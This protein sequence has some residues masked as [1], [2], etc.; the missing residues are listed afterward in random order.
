MGSNLPGAPKHIAKGTLLFGYLGLTN[1]RQKPR[2]RRADGG[3][4]VPRF[5]QAQLAIHRQPDL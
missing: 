4:V 1:V 2:M 5:A 3:K